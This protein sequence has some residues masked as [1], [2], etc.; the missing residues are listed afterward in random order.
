MSPSVSGSVDPEVPVNGGGT[1]NGGE[2]NSNDNGVKNESEVPSI[3]VEKAKTSFQDKA[4]NYLVEQVRNVVIP[5]FAKWFDMN[6]VHDIEKKLFPDFFP[7]AN[8]KGS[9]YR[10]P[11]TYK[12]MRDFMVNCYRLNPLEYLTVTAVRRNLAGDVTNVIR[13]HNFLEKWGLINYQIDPRTKPTTIGPQYTGHFQVTLDTPRGLVPFIPEDVQAVSNGNLP[14]PPTSVEPQDH[15]IEP[16]EDESKDQDSKTVPLNMEVRR[17]VYNDAETGSNG[18]SLQ[19]FCNVTGTET[20]EVRYHNLKSKNLS[21]NLSST[22]NNATNISEECFEQGLFPSNFH[23]ADF[24]KLNKQKEGENWSEQEILLLLEGIEMYGTFDLI[25]NSNINQVNSNSNGQWVKISEH[26]GSKTKE[27]CIIKFIQ[28]P[29]EDRYLHKLINREGA[30][31]NGKIDKEVIIQDIVSKL[32]EKNEGQALV[33]KNSERELDEIN[34]DTTNLINQITELT[35]EK[36]DVKLNNL[37]ELETSLVKIENQLTLERK[38]LSI[39]RWL[40][41]EKIHKFRQQTN[42]PELN[43]LLDELLTPVKLNEVNS[44]FNKK[45]DLNDQSMETKAN[46]NE[47]NLPISLTKPKSYRFWSG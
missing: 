25:D 42:N 44:N 15:K 22:V 39:E 33:Q 46:D 12:H 32:I 19:Y 35:L 4:Q 28:L 3:D 5:S 47:V 20:N 17:N 13:I 30:K 37:N 24:V 2:D 11:D 7:S 6:K 38:Q 10:T 21:N 9:A 18:T 34:K 16:S 14:S 45:I 1:P 23:S 36:V 41:Y 43:S 40:Q 27:Q 29:I 26:V 31:N 8:E